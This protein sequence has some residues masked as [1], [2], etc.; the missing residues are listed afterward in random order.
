MTKEK[1][2]VRS[3]VAA[4][5]TTLSPTLLGWGMKLTLSRPNMVQPSLSERFYGVMYM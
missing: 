4:K 1:T 3:S 2:H 5:T